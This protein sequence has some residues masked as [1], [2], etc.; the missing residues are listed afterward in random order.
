[1]LELSSCSPTPGAC[2]HVCC[3]LVYMCVV[4]L[5]TCVLFACVH[6]CLFLFAAVQRE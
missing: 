1:M 5:C 6:V 2:V 3:L 4:S